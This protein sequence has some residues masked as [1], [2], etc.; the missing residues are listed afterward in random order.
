MLS[1]IKGLYEAWEAER[2]ERMK[3]EKIK[4]YLTILAGGIALCAVVYCVK[5]VKAFF[6]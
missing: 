5:K 2:Q 1:W 4:T 3:M 6:S